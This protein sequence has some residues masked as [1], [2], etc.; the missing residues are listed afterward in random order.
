MGPRRCGPTQFSVLMRY[1]CGNFGCSE[2]LKWSSR[3]IKYRV[4]Y[5][6]CCSWFGGCENLPRK[7]GAHL[8]EGRL[9]GSDASDGW[10]DK[11]VM[12]RKENKRTRLDSLTF[13]A[14]SDF[15]E[16]EFFCSWGW[17]CL[18]LFR[19]KRRLGVGLRW[20]RV[21]HSKLVS[22]NGI[23]KVCEKVLGSNLIGWRLFDLGGLGFT[24]FSLADVSG[25]AWQVWLI[26][27][28]LGLKLF[29]KWFKVVPDLGE[30]FRSTRNHFSS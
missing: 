5:W 30:I 19:L 9:G 1:R 24:R 27:L 28:T 21:Q 8:E 10:D 17:A 2:K 14:I 26:Y 23:R 15:C 25:V 13:V 12:M 11:I 4:S 22:S 6:Y 29:L 16:L 18:R 20:L 7:R 3:C